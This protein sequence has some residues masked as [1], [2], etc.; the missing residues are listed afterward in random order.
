MDE[1]RAPMGRDVKVGKETLW[2]VVGIPGKL[3]AK[4][5]ARPKRPMRIYHLQ[6]KIL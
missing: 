1:Q 6:Q 3:H 5:A 4:I 2:Y